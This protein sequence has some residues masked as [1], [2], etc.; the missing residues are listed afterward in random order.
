MPTHLQADQS[1]A[2]PMGRCWALGCVLSLT[3]P[4][5]VLSVT[6][7]VGDAKP[8]RGDE[9][10]SK[11]AGLGRGTEATIAPP[12]CGL[13]AALAHEASLPSHQAESCCYPSPDRTAAQRASDISPRAGRGQLDVHGCH[14][15]SLFHQ[16]TPV[17]AVSSRRSAHHKEK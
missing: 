2:S 7:C 15:T 5:R 1:A 6:E 3:T 4:A 10:G 8:G 12:E 13:H 16:G 17:S 11:E 14:K 9:R